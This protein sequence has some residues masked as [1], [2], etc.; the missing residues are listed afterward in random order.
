M[1]AQV[2]NNGLARITAAL[3]G[4][5]FWLGW[6]TGNSVA[7]SANDLVSV[8]S[9]ARVVATSAQGTKTVANDSLTLIGTITAVAP[10]TITEVGAFDAASGGNIDLYAD[11]A[12][13]NLNAGDSL[14]YTLN[15]GFA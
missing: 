3:L 10:R 11:F 7:K 14:A 15:L 4:L 9:E 2:Q 12:V 8:A 1:T 6:G 13:V 5:T